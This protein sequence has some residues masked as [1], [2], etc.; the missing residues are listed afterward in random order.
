LRDGSRRQ[1]SNVAVNAIARNTG[2]PIGDSSV[3]F[4]EAGW[5]QLFQFD[6]TE[7]VWGRRGFTPVINVLAYLTFEDID[8]TMW[9]VDW[10]GL[11]L[12]FA[13]WRSWNGQRHAKRPRSVP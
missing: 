2:R 7:E 12:R 5:D 4:I 9:K 3:E 11:V 13:R 6:T 8:E 1:I 10:Q